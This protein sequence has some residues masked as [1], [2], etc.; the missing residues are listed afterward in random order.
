LL[1][2]VLQLL[3]GPNARTVVD[4]TLGGG[5]HAEALLERLPGIGLLVG[6][7]R[8][9]EAV[10]RA[11]LRLAR[12]GGRVKTM[13]AHFAD[14]GE[15]LDTMGVGKVDAVLMDL[16]V[17]SF[18]LE[19]GARGFSFQKDGP[20]DMR[21]DKSFH[22][23]ARDLV[24]GYSQQELTSIFWKYGEESAAKKISKAI[25]HERA[26]APITSTLQLAGIV[27]SAAPRHGR[28]GV[29]PATR[30]FQ[31]I[32]IAVNGELDRLE[33]AAQGAVDR[34]NPGGRLAIISFHSL[35]DRIVKN[36]FLDMAGRCVCP[37]GLPVCVCG[38]REMVKILTKKPVQPGA[39]EVAQNPRA[40]SAKLRAVEK[41][42]QAAWGE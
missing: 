8:D 10:Q 26:I 5:G 4:A 36:V 28:P 7:D 20:L 21:M 15:V 18:Q 19:D 38:R 39:G 35:E 16:G 23:S 9:E 30:V 3:A 40:R 25:V 29:H 6:L 32:R 14:M 37:P 41:T 17:S 42:G 24:N 11:A 34:L 31:A 33:E 27:E 12:F 22:T 1:E 2:E 13:K